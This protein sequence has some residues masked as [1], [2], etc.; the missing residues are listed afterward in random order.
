[1]TEPTDDTLP[2][3]SAEVAEQ[4]FADFVA[5]VVKLYET[6]YASHLRG[7]SGIVVNCRLG[8]THSLTSTSGTHSHRAL[9][10]ELIRHY[11]ACEGAPHAAAEMLADQALDQ[12][13]HLLTM[14]GSI[15]KSVDPVSEPTDEALADALDDDAAI[16]ARNEE[17]IMSKLGE[18]SDG[19]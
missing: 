16:E 19:W 12:I 18:D 1:M 4:M 6:T 9:A 8:E 10:R 11:A 5:E 15:K 14:V 3:P 13:D 17:R 2:Y 7:L